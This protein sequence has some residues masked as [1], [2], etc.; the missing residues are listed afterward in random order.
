MTLPANKAFVEYRHNAEGAPGSTYR[1][2][3]AG[4]FYLVY[5][6]WIPT[7]A[8]RAIAARRMVD[9]VYEEAGLDWPS[10]SP[11]SRS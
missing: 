4:W 6:A 3:T 1:D 11:S 5:H 8:Y 10:S 9:E 2:C 7:E